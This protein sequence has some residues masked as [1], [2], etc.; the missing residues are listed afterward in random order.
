MRL[1]KAFMAVLRFDESRNM[2]MKRSG[3]IALISMMI[4]SAVA[5]VI[6]VGLLLRAIGENQMAVN[7][8]LA[9]RAQLAATSCAEYALG[10]LRQNNAYAG[11]ATLTVDSGDTC[12]IGVP[13]GSGNTNRTLVT[14]STILDVTQTESISITQLR[15]QLQISSWQ[16][17][18][19]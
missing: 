12:Y 3:F 11:N 15:P 10:Q 4:I 2:M 16:D 9:Q 18:I 8:D 1:A 17:V 6:A 7:N 14:T 5:T 19:N 13:G